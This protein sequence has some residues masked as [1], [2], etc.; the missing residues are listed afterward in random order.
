MRHCFVYLVPDEPPNDGHLPVPM[1]M[2]EDDDDDEEDDDGAD[3]EAFNDYYHDFDEDDDDDSS[4][5]AYQ[6]HVIGAS[7]GTYF[8]N[9][10]S[11]GISLF[12]CMLDER[13]V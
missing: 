13:L 3:E 7:F 10:T 1:A 5:D 4:H 12:L 11:V 8:G 6:N 9:A 2:D